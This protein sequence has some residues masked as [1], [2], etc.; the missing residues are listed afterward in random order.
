MLS[1]FEPANPNR[2][3]HFQQ[4]AVLSGRP[5]HAFEQFHRIFNQ[6]ARCAV[7]RA[8]GPTASMTLDPASG[9]V[10]AKAFSIQGGSAGVSGTVTYA[11]PGGGSGTITVTKGIITNAT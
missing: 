4:Q 11:K 5:R 7:G 2:R 9:T 3:I 6:R 1:L 8:N 10:Y